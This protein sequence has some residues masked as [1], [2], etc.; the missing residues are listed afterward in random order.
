RT[1]G[2][3]PLELVPTRDRA[4][5]ELLLTADYV[6]PA[7]VAT[8]PN[9]QRQAPVALLGDHPVVHVFEPVELP[10]EAELWNPPDLLRDLLDLLAP[11][12]DGDEPL[13]D[14]AEDQI[15]PTAPARRVAVSV[16]VGVVEQ[17][18]LPQ[19]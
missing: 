17:S 13:L 3:V 5:F 9:R 7:A 15:G 8:G 12:I 2:R 10:L 19:I 1:V 4:L 16:W 11:R 14:Q 18:L 6:E